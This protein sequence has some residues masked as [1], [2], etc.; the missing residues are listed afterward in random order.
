MPADPASRVGLGEGASQFSPV[1]V[2]G[3]RQG[4]KGEDLFQLGEELVGVQPLQVQALLEQEVV[5]FLADQ[6]RS[7]AEPRSTAKTLHLKRGELHLH[8][9]DREAASALAH[10]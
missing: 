7:K 6:E 9:R 10:Q 4:G 2:E 5:Q 3:Q 8:R 1:R